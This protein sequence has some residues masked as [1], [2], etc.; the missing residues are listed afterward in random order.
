MT[1]T[2]A[3]RTCRAP[4]AGGDQAGF[5][6]AREGRGPVA[7]MGSLCRGDGARDERG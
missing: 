1:V 2:R 3:L 5:Q 4:R 7:V 6:S